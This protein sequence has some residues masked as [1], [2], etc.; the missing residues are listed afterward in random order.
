MTK[1]VSTNTLLVVLHGPANNR[2]IRIEMNFFWA[3]KIDITT[4]GTN[5]GN[6]NKSLQ[7]VPICGLQNYSFTMFAWIW[8]LKVVNSV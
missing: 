4:D 2:Q 7:L 8:P 1:K 5:L 3:Q 6:R